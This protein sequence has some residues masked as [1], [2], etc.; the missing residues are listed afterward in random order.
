MVQLT[1]AAP[2]LP[3]SHFVI[4]GTPLRA[5]LVARLGEQR[6]LAAYSALA[7]AL[8]ALRWLIVAYL[9]VALP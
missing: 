5:S 4:S 9:R 8:V 6:Y 2:L 1:L 7:L 3:P